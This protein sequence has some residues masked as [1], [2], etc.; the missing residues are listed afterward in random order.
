MEPL[1]SGHQWSRIKCL[2]IPVGCPQFKSG[3]WGGKRCPASEVS[4]SG[5]RG[6]HCAN[7]CYTDPALCADEVYSHYYHYYRRRVAPKVDVRIVIAVTITV[8][9]VLQVR[10]TIS[11]F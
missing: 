6:V 5:N 1:L 7:V 8:I 9:S 4:S 10:V 11:S 3:T 2:Y